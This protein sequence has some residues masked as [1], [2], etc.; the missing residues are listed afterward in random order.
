[1][2]APTIKKYLV[3]RKIAGRWTTFNGAMQGALAVPELYDSAKHAKALA[4][5]GQNSDEDLL[6]VYC[7]A[8]A[9]T[10]DHLECVVKSRYYSGSGHRIYNLVPACRT[11]N[12]KKGGKPWA[13][14][15]LEIGGADEGL[16]RER[17]E[18]FAQ[19]E[20]V[21]RFGWDDI[22]R[23]LPDL[24]KRYQE[25]ITEIRGKL[26]EADDLAAQIRAKAASR[27]ESTTARR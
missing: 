25:L 20:L 8:A 12:E 9:A 11:C 18:R 10:W 7:G 3:P 19:R 13:A 4:L 6:C 26:K 23:E 5:L 14:F 27:R 1:M 2:K 22:V 17:L 15:L 24:A 21:E 16:R